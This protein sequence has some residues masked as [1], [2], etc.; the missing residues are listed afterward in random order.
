MRRTPYEIAHR[1]LPFL[2]FMERHNFINDLLGDRM[3]PGHYWHEIAKDLGVPSVYDIK[4]NP[5]S[6]SG[7]LG[8]CLAFKPGVT[9][10][11]CLMSAC[12]IVKPAQVGPDG[13]MEDVFRYFTLEHGISFDE[14]R[15]PGK[16]TVLGE[17][18]AEGN[19]FNYGDGPRAISSDFILAVKEKATGK[20]PTGH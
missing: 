11:H 3:P 17:W 1:V 2:F 5:I 16:R 10:A 9:L 8:L 20:E 19:H 12:I 14:G 18:D 4:A 6:G 7:L 13:T 15:Q